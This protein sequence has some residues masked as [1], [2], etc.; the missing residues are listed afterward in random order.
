MQSR[1]STM[2]CGNRDEGQ[3][4]GGGRLYNHVSEIRF[5][6]GAGTETVRREDRGGWNKLKP[7]LGANH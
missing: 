5:I 7:A 4:E 1:L 6:E 3:Q 2:A